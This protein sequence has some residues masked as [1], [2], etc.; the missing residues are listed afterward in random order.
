M[1]K[2]MLFFCLGL[3]ICF[4][5]SGAWAS[6]V[7][8]MGLGNPWLMV[9]DPDTD[10][11]YNPAWVLKAPNQAFGTYLF[12]YGV[13]DYERS[14]GFYADPAAP[15][16]LDADG[17]TIG[18]LGGVGA[19]Y[20]VWRGK[21]GLG[22]G[23][24]HERLDDDGYVYDNTGTPVL[25]LVNWPEE[26]MQ[27]IMVQAVYAIP[28][29]AAFSLGAS[30][31]WDYTR[32]AVDYLVTSS[33][34][35]AELYEYHRWDVTVGGAWQLD[36]RL[37]L[38]LSVGGGGYPGK[39]RY[40]DPAFGELKGDY[41]GG[42]AHCLGS[43]YYHHN[44]RLTFPIIVQWLWDNQKYDDSSLDYDTSWWEILVGVGTTY[45]INQDAAF[46][47][48][49][50]FYYAY[51]DYGDDTS[52]SITL[53]ENGWKRHTIELR[54]GLEGKIWQELMLRGGIYYRYQFYDDY[55]RLSVGNYDLSGDGWAQTL[56]IGVG[57][58]YTFFD[59]LT[60]DIGAD[61]PFMGEDHVTMDGQ[62]PN[63]YMSDYD[64]NSLFYQ[65]GVNFTYLF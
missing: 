23:Y 17:D 46:L 44:D 41:G 18:H 53:F 24:S 65:V 38:G 28:L 8:M 56:G 26:T 31:S 19:I 36:S 13:H 12:G 49:G 14:Y 47:V 58:S 22:V 15:Y 3:F 62:I 63:P 21:L 30:A 7:R 5:S 20:D 43:L 48:G 6:G 60:V 52:S 33:V 64:G 51:R 27:D 39:Y 32:D 16:L 2:A 40:S 45:L 59:R 37:E 1:K 25:S 4:F 57:L 11:V 50:G 61:I 10:W 54:A 55:K 42:H 35:V 9:P 29:N 34:P